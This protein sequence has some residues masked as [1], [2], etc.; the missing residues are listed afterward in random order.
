MSHTHPTSSPTAAPAVLRIE[1]LSI[2]FG[3]GS[4]QRTVVSGLNL[5]CLL[6]TSPSPRD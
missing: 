3:S 6:Y 2:R 1:N 5:T 4:E